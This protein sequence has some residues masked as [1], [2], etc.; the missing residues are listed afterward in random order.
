MLITGHQSQ[1]QSFWESLEITN[2]SS[3]KKKENHVGVRVPQ[4]TVVAQWRHLVVIPATVPCAVRGPCP[5]LAQMLHSWCLWVLASIAEG[6][7]TR[8]SIL[9]TEK[10][11][12]GILRRNLSWVT[13]S[14]ASFGVS[15]STIM[16]VSMAQ[17]HAKPY[18]CP[19]SLDP[20]SP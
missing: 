12:K 14:V 15:H 5:T 3:R 8:Q 10:V 20:P 6:V 7:W 13:C 17:H 1:F 9:L 16:A 2:F 19:S 11:R 18:A 4:L